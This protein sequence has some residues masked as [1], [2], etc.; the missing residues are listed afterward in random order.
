MRK[1]PTTRTRKHPNRGARLCLL[2][3][4]TAVSAAFLVTN[5]ALINDAWQMGITISVIALMG[6]PWLWGRAFERYSGHAF[7]S[8]LSR[9]VRYKAAALFCAGLVL[10]AVCISGVIPRPAWMACAIVAFLAGII[11]SLAVFIPTAPT[12]KNSG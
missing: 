5:L 9:P 6:L 8:L 1:R 2:I 12:A 7:T 10:T 11:A 4:G 3:A